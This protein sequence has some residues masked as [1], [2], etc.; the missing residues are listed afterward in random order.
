MKVIAQKTAAITGA[1]SGIGRI[2]AVHLA[3]E[4]CRLAI[5]DID[6]TGLQKTAALIGAH[7]KFL[8][9]TVR[10]FPVAF[11]TLSARVGDWV[12]ASYARKQSDKK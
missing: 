9:L 7:A 6:G 11:V 3:K 2:L 4:G 8:D 5:A 10:C 1:A 12:A